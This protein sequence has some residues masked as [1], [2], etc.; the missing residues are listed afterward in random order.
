VRVPFTSALLAPLWIMG[1]GII[2]AVAPPSGVVLGL[3]LL[4]ACV[5][6]VP[7]IITSLRGRQRS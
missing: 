2:A 1:V 6:V 5:V 3:F 7:A 4:L